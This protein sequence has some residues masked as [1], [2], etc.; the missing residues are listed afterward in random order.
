VYR[1]TAVLITLFLS[2]ASAQVRAA[3]ETAERQTRGAQ[4]FLEVN[5]VHYVGGDCLFT[6]LDKTGSF[7]IEAKGLSAQVRV[8]ATQEGDASWS[9]PQGGD[10]TAMPVGEVYSDKRGCWQSYDLQEKETYMCAWD[11][12]QRLY[13]GPMPVEPRWSLSWGERGGMYARIISSSGLDTDHASVTAEKSRDGAIYLCRANH[14]YSTECIRHTLEDDPKHDARAKAML[15]ANCKTGKYT[16]FYGRN[17][18]N[19]D[20]DILD[21]D[22]NDKLSNAAGGT[23]VAQTAFE[24]LCP[25]AAAA[26]R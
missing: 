8:K 2:C 14:D 3:E 20:D 1:V 17:L 12:S 16:D 7:R 6:P 15:H 11:K 23:S 26:T 4:C 10:A 18:Q 19:L 5:G 21:L 9:G 25:K 22:T 24:A 13:L